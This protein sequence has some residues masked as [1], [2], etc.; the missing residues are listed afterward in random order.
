MEFDNDEPITLSAHALAALQEF[1]DE[2]KKRLEVFEQLYK[3]SEEDFDAKNESQPTNNQPVSIDSFSEDW[4]LSQF[5]YTDETSKIL[6]KA[7]LEGA[8]EDTVVVIAS[9]PAVYAAMMNFSKEELPTDKIY[10][11]EYDTRF[12]LLAGDK[13]YQYDYNTPNAIPEILRHKCHRLLID[14]PFLE[15]ECQKKSAMAARKMLVKNHDLKTK[16]GDLQFKLISSTGERMKSIMEETYPEC[17]TTS[18]L[19]EHKNGLSNE[20]RCY[21]SFECSQ[22]TFQDDL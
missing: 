18:F 21:A 20:F 8:D 4:Q 17:Q 22:W 3:K 12:K 10:L 7:L 1:K 13:F 5:W 6:G 15:E 9:A 16:N 11:L 19:P 2:E 14:P